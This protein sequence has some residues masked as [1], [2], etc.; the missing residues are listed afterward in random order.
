[1]KKIILKINFFFILMIFILISYQ[2]S[3]TSNYSKIPTPTVVNEAD[4]NTVRISGTEL[5]SV[6]SFNIQKFFQPSACMYN[7]LRV[8]KGIV[9]G[10]KLMV[11]STI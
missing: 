8:K 7:I 9:C 6:F 2:K 1:M 3:I 4:L 10:V 5:I 11:T